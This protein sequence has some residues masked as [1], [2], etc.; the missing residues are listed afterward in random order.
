MA[1]QWGGSCGADRSCRPG[2][3][4]SSTGWRGARQ[5]PG[6]VLGPPLADPTRRAADQNLCPW[7]PGAPLY[8]Q[9]QRRSPLLSLVPSPLL[10]QAW[11]LCPRGGAG[12]GRQWV[13]AL[14]EG[15]R[16]EGAVQD[17]VPAP[18]VELGGSQVRGLSQTWRKRRDQ[19]LDA[20]SQWQ[21]W[22][23]LACHPGTREAEAGGQRELGA[24]VQPTPRSETPSQKST[25]G[26]GRGRGRAR[27]AAPG[28]RDL[29]SPR[30]ASPAP[31]R[32]RRGHEMEMDG[33]EARGPGR[34]R[35]SRPARKVW[36]WRCT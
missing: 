31:L 5:S 19:A 35:L 9:H 3:T 36:A 21:G 15:R 26:N 18:G 4:S 8:P 24:A 10:G 11:T 25:S 14:R 28:L 16:E 30:P 22:W 23:V 20:S 29:M 2:L 32:L 27:R 1:S 17:G 13:T 6:Q 33:G 7:R 12:W 34:S